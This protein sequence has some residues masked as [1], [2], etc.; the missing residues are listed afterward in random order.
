MP[1][2]LIGGESVEGSAAKYAMVNPAQPGIA[3]DRKGAH[4]FFNKINE[5]F[6]DAADCN[7]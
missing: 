5:T 2:Y 4:A 7:F 1:S 6:G 3:L